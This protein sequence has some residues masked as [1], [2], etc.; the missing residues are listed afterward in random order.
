MSPCLINIKVCC[1]IWSQQH[2]STY[3]PELCKTFQADSNCVQWFEECFLGTHWAPQYALN[4]ILNKAYLSLLLTRCVT[5]WLPFSHL[6]VLYNGYLQH[7]NAACYKAL[8]CWLYGHYNEFILLQWTHK[9]LN[10]SNRAPLGDS[11]DE[12]ATEKSV[13]MCL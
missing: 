3:L 7:D 10:F 13:V 11:Q 1:R 4:I 2:K 5:L 9:S 12:C 6:T 8:K